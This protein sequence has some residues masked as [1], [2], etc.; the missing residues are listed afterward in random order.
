MDRL[1]RREDL[2]GGGFD[3]ERRAAK[4]LR[5]IESRIATLRAEARRA[6]ETYFIEG[7]DH[8]QRR[9]GDDYLRGI[10][11]AVE[12]DFRPTLADFE[13]YASL[14]RAQVPADAAVRA[15]FLHALAQR[16]SLSAARAPGLLAAVGYGDP[17]TMRAY[18]EAYGEHQMLDTLAVGD[19][20]DGA[21]GVTTAEERTLADL[22]ASLQWLRLPGGAVLFQAGEPSDA[23]YILIGGRLRVVA[24]EDGGEQVVAE[25]GRGELVGEIEA[26]TEEPRT[27]TAITLRDSDLVRLP[28]AAL[29]RLAQAYP[30]VL[31]RL[32]R[33]LAGRLQARIAGPARVPNTL[34]T[35]A[36]VPL[37]PGA[38]VAA[39]AERLAGTLA[40]LGSTLHL[41]SR[42]VDAQL[43]AGTAQL[44]PGQGD[45]GELV[46][47]LSEAESEHRYVLY[48][49]D[50]TPTAWTDRCVRQ[51][52]RVVLLAGPGMDSVPGAE[53]RRLTA[54]LRALP[55]LV[56]VHP[57]ATQAPSGT[58][59]WRAPR[60]LHAHYH[61][62]L[63]DAAQMRH[64]AR[65]LT[66]NAVGVVLGGGGARG[67]AHIG[68]MR[69]L[70]EAGVEVD[71]IGGTSMGAILGAGYAVG[72]DQDE[73][74]RL[75]LSTAS[76]SA[77]LDP[78]LPMV[79]FFAGRKLAKLLREQ[80][81]GACF[82][83]LWRPFF[84]ISSNLTRAE[85]VV[86]DEGLIWRA[87]RASTAIPGLFP[88]VLH[89]N[90]DVLV[91]GGNMNNL[92]IDVMR[93]R[94]EGGTVIGVDVSG[95]LE[96]VKEYSF[97]PTL[98]GWEVLRDR[99]RRSPRVVQ[100]PLLLGTLMRT[101]VIH[102]AAAMRAPTFRAAAD[103]II[104]P[105]VGRFP[106]LEFSRCAEIIE[107]AYWAAK[108]VVEDW[109]RQVRTKNRAPVG[110]GVHAR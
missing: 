72:H 39:F 76:R 69:A 18:V 8:F 11:A 4:L 82:E 24:P 60:H 96:S 61:V 87:V 2:L 75:A 73:M 20:P 40:E 46:A 90:G 77:L 45:D 57:P 100:A 38:P 86:H 35:F 99:M 33:I 49:A 106:V 64:L 3:A 108:P 59:A 97:G 93:E 98:S 21:A 50:P 81:G 52:D 80:T 68:V 58:R 66:G 63:E 54:S 32:N 110:G 10:K 107:A 62:R 67:Y 17:A 94:Y 103:L 88:P 36:V 6:I 7:E 28:R 14:W 34:I 70:A 71:M 44:A 84:C 25:L 9:V 51:S 1:V 53:E 101:T 102:G 85:T 15:A 95:A 78:T 105:P 5:R 109:L 22:E 92:P 104:E 43:G 26:L 27:T 19:G 55:D 12:S 13:R 42:R 48:E 37:G 91:D 41:S 65:R 79:S 83:D 47:W 30:Q 31:L 23:L 56:L 16:F 29:L 74:T 89:T